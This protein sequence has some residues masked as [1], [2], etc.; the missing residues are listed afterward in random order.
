M[1]IFLFFLY[2]SALAFK[3]VIKSRDLAAPGCS[4]VFFVF[5]GKSDNAS[6]F[7]KHT[8]EILLPQVVEKPFREVPFLV[9]LY[10]TLTVIL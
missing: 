1:K 9:F 6:F 4:H 7:T 2:N 10:F 8:K 3:L 5:G